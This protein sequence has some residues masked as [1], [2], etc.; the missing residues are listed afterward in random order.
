M[1]SFKFY[2]IQSDNEDEVIFLLGVT[3]ILQIDFNDPAEIFIKTSQEIDHLIDKFVWKRRPE[4]GDREIKSDETLLDQLEIPS[5]LLKSFHSGFNVL[6][7]RAWSVAN[8]IHE[9]NFS[10]S[11]PKYRMTFVHAD[12]VKDWRSLIE[13][14]DAL[15]ANWY[16]YKNHEWDLTFLDLSQGISPG[17]SKRAAFETDVFIISKISPTTAQFIKLVRTINPKAKM[18]IHAF[19]SPSVYFANTYLYDLEKYLYEEDLW[20]MSCEADKK[21]AELSWENIN[22][23]IMPL[24][25]PSRFLNTKISTTSKNIFY[26]GRISEQKNL[27]EALMAIFLIAPQMREESRKFIVYGY[28]DFLGLPNL[29]IPS[30][31]YLEYIYRFTTQLGLSDLVEFHPA[32]PQD[33]ILEKL[34]EGIFLSTSIHSDENFGLVAYRALNA[35]IPVILTD[36]GGHKDFRHSFTNVNFIPVYGSRKTP[37]INPFELAEILLKVPALETPEKIAKNHFTIDLSGI[38]PIKLL[39]PSALKIGISEKL[40]NTFPWSPRKWPLYGKVFTSFDDP[41]FQTAMKIYGAKERKKARPENTVLLPSVKITEGEIVDHGCLTGILRLQ[42]KNENKNIP[43]KQLGKE[44]EVLVSLPEWSWL[45]E[46]GLVS[47]KGEI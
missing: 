5:H 47:Y 17:V 22:S 42:R 6:V 23:E 36:W 20:L 27:H 34:K 41:N 4:T 35:G 10:R 11:S 12:E 19:E 37:H 2:L 39:K 26:F 30:Q 44:R 9:K 8:L 13:A 14:T 16:K 1:A 38:E 18:I 40:K 24:K 33:T 29:R 32:V 43:L 46:N 45:W 7:S 21:L 15:V 3:S 31:G 25:T 28:E